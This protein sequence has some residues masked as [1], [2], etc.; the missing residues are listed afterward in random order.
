LRAAHS[1]LL[2]WAASEGREG[3]SKRI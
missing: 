1:A 3:E 2:D